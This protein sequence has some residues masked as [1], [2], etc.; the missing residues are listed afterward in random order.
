MIVRLLFVAALLC[1][2]ACS[3]EPPLDLTEVTIADLQQNMQRGELSAEQLTE[4]YLDRIEAV[5]RNGPALRSVI[6]IN[7]DVLAIARSLDEER[8]D[9]GPRGPMHGIPVLL[10]A[11]IDTGDKMPTSAGSLALA[12]HIAPDDA[13]LV[14]RL[15]E[16]GAIILGKTNLSEWANFRSDYSSSGWSSVGGQT[17]NPYEPDRNP[18]GSSSGSGVAVAANLTAV[19]VGTET[20]GSVVCPS[21]ANGIVGIKPDAGPGQPGRH[22]PDRPQPGYSRSDGANR[23]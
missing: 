16:S 5:D 17:R 13:F 20:N 15:R 10:K 2:A 12:D 8:L 11:N 1:L 22:H 14:Q 3:D 21:G 4:W 6:E 18:C 7:P 19:A 9:S 23:A